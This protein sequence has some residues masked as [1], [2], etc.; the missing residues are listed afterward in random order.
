M[1]LADFDSSKKIDSPHVFEGHRLTG[2][3]AFYFG[4]A[5]HT[6]STDLARR[7]GTYYQNGEA[8]VRRRVNQ[9]VTALWEEQVPVIHMCV[10]MPLTQGKGIL[11]AMML[12]KIDF[13]TNDKENGGY[14]PKKS[15]QVFEDFARLCASHQAQQMVEHSDF[16]SVSIGSH[17]Q[18]L[19]VDFQ[20][21]T[22]ALTVEVQ[23][24]YFAIKAAE[25]VCV[26]P[27]SSII[28][29]VCKELRQVLSTALHQLEEHSAAVDK[30]R[31][32]LLKDDGCKAYYRQQPPIFVTSKGSS[33]AWNKSETASQWQKEAWTLQKAGH[34]LRQPRVRKPEDASSSA[35]V[36]ES[37]P[38]YPR[39]V[40]ELR[41]SPQRANNL[42]TK[43]SAAA[44]SGDT[45]DLCKYL[46]NIRGFT[47]EVAEQYATEAAGL[48]VEPFHKAYKDDFIQHIAAHLA[49]EGTCKG[50]SDTA[51]PKKTQ[52]K[53]W[54]ARIIE[55]LGVNKTAQADTLRTAQADTL[56]SKIADA[57]SSNNTDDLWK[58]LC[59]FK[60]AGGKRLAEVAKQ[61][62]T[63][64]FG[65]IPVDLKT[66]KP[67]VYKTEF[68][69][70]I[71]NKLVS[72][73]G[74]H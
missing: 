21:Q 7:G 30:L 44:A 23:E 35:H 65:G 33:E 63:E 70:H 27:Q 72:E 4:K 17:D 68:I 47:K 62:A 34:A 74:D 38:L 67:C 73:F 22:R 29:D 24:A 43:M 42:E 36:A 56:W 11:E 5:G 26:K 13:C 18:E 69:R 40:N 8:Q 58:Y 19:H 66:Y 46:K 53:T 28:E 60:G 14:R 6:E 59:N 1:L 45:K 51:V 25:S 10:Q 15:S 52:S 2:I 32:Q 54:Y 50:A 39:I 16:F 61:Y 57:A 48:E 37:K 71:A 20:L 49:S 3:R 9:L 55:D 41:F 64:I 12:E 31:S